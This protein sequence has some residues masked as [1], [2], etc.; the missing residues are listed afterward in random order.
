MTKVIDKNINLRQNPKPILFYVTAKNKVHKI[1][2]TF[3]TKND[4]FTILLTRPSNCY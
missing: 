2:V 4:E 3:I 1:A